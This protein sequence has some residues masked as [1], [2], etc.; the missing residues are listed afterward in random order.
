[1]VNSCCFIKKL[2][3]IKHRDFSRKLL[4]IPR[5]NDRTTDYYFNKI[6]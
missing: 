5:P 1:M 2:V 3:K 6:H 4:P